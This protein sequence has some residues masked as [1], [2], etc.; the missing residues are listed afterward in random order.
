[1]YIVIPT[2]IYPS[3]G[4]GFVIGTVGSTP[5]YFNTRDDLLTYL[6]RSNVAPGR[7]FEAKELEYNIDVKLTEKSDPKIAADPNSAYR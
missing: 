5:L 3:N 4:N 2:P 1:M 7:I 6:K